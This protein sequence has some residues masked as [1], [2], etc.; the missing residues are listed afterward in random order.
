MKARELK[1]WRPEEARD[2]PISLVLIFFSGHATISLFFFVF[3]VILC[4]YGVLFE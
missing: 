1:Q 4:T 3:F 2:V